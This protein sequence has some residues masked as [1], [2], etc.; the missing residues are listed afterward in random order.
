[1]STMKKYLR[2]TEEVRGKIS[3][4]TACGGAVWRHLKNLT[5]LQHDLLGIFPEDHIPYHR[6]TCIFVLI[7]DIH[8]ITKK[9]KHHKCS[10]TDEW[11]IKMLHIHI[12]RFYST[13]NKNAIMIF[14]NN[15]DRKYDTK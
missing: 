1:M 2:Y 15:W 4:F 10:S 7:D 8:I 12:I 14:Q 13:V 9:W 6:N 11:V 5:I 3:L